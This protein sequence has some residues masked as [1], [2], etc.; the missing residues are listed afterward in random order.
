[1]MWALE[2]DPDLFLTYEDPELA[3]DKSEESKSKAKSRQVGKYER[4]NMK[5]AG[6]AAE[7][8]LPIS[9]FLVASVLKD[10]SDILL[11]EARGLDDVVKVFY[12]IDLQSYFSSLIYMHQQFEE[13]YTI[14]CLLFPDT[15]WC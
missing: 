11:T 10:K 14:V 9:V 12:Y 15:E 6:K 4:E 5:N 13:F 3:A 7:T 8:P 1:M 2:Y